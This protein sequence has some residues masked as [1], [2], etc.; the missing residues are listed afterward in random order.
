MIQ[1]GLFITKNKDK[2]LYFKKKLTD[3]LSDN[4]KIQFVFLPNKNSVK[5]YISTLNILLTYNIEEDFFNLRSD[6]LKWIHIGNAGV[7]N[8]LI[9]E[10]LKSKVIISNSR[11][12]NSVPV[13]EYVMSTILYFSK[14]FQDCIIFKKSKKWTQWEIAK[15]NNILENKFVG[16]IGYGAIGKEIAKKSKAFNMKVIAIRRLQKKI[17]K[18][19]FVDELMPMNKLNYLLAKSDFVIIACPL[20]PLTRHM[21]NKANLK[22]IRKTSYL[23]NISRGEVI[24]ENDLICSLKTKKIKGAALDVFSKEPLHNNSLFFNL[25]NVFI[26]PH[27]SGN[28]KGYQ[29]S[30][31]DSFADN[32]NRYL[33]NKP[34]KNRVCKKRMY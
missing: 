34:L 12:I 29:E 24:N 17:E 19:K 28:F 10:V 31:I 3:L 13:S 1:V 4:N 16:I 11:G 23:I 18:N 32:L 21:I 22:L 9:D 5:K 14:Q 7:D 6:T 15:K 30:V 2:Y 26:S 33:S 20:T 8:C 25:D 27:I